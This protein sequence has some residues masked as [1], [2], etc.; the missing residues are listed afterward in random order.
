MA[1]VAGPPLR[2]RLGVMLDRLTGPLFVARTFVGNGLIHPERPDRLVRA[3]GK[4]KDW[5]PTI[6]GGYQ[7][8][9]ARRPDA[10][11]LVDERGALT[12][13]EIDD[14]LD[15]AVRDQPLAAV[16]RRPG[17]EIGDGLDQRRQRRNGPV[18]DELHRASRAPRTGTVK[19]PRA[20]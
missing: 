17:R 11:A 15:G 7:A 2:S 14:D 4:L 16:A 18:D 19:R 5:G 3:L 13:R 20:T 1:G 12:F 9:A 6:A 10:I 8:A